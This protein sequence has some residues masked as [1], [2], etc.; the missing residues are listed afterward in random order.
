MGTKLTWVR[1]Q[2]AG[3]GWA[4]GDHMESESSCS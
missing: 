1:A 2:L 3:M 4:S